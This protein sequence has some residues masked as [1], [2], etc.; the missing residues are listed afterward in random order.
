MVSKI[1]FGM[2]T[3]NIHSLQSRIQSHWRT[4]DF[5][6]STSELIPK[7]NR[8][9]LLT[10]RTGTPIYLFRMKNKQTNKQQTIT[11]LCTLESTSLDKT[12]RCASKWFILSQRT[13]V[14]L[15][16]VTYAQ[17]ITLLL[18][19]VQRRGNGAGGRGLNQGALSHEVKASALLSITPIKNVL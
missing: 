16:C 9:R 15:Q 13:L 19:A 8:P 11:I 12:I 7:K 17:T 2:S 5:D 4:A 14:N 18:N 3:T 10:L 1:W 6:A